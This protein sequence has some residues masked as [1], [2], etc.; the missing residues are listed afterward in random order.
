[1]AEANG[2]VEAARY[3]G[4]TAGPVLGGALAAAG[5]TRLGL[6]IDAA[7]FLAVAAAGWRCTRA[8][9]PAGSADGGAEAAAAGAALRR[10]LADRTL[11]I[12]MA[13]AVASLLFFTMRSRPRSSSPA[14]CSTPARPATGCSCRRGRSAW[15]PARSGSPGCVPA[16]R[17]AAGALPAS[18]SRAP[19]SSAPRRRHDG[20]ALVGFLVGGV[21]HG[22]KNVLLRTLI[23]ERVPGRAARPRVRG[24][25]RAA[26]RRR[27]VRARRPA[28]CSSASRAPRLALALAG[29]VPLAI[30]RRRAAAP[31]P[32]AWPH[33]DPEEDRVCT[34][35]TS[36]AGTGPRP[37]LTRRRRLRRRRARRAAL[38]VRRAHQ[39]RPDRPGHHRVRRPGQGPAAGLH[40]GSPTTRPPPGSRSS[41]WRCAAQVRWCSATSGCAWIART[42][43]AWTPAW[44]A[45]SPA[46]S[47][48]GSTEPLHRP[49]GDRT[50]R[51]GIAGRRATHR[52]AGALRGAARLR[53]AG[54]R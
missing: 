37:R 44:T 10:L 27:A 33:P 21:A 40:D 54:V 1:M 8:A 49:T 7:S 31:L 26:Q 46:D 9:A 35:P 45:C 29:R 43:C 32:P 15:S 39:A 12:A 42:P 16:R 5:L 38:A 14:R 34:Q 48:R 47:D 20:L 18:P 28:A 52:A 6:L 51:W 13:A 24:L 50:V 4:M 53:P 11:A 3:L 17:L 30:G 41:T 36:S 23:H 25:Q 2:H 22:V 19:G